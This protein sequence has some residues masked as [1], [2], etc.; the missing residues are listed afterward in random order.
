MNTC[1]YCKK[2]K[3]KRNCPALNGVICSQCC[4]KSRIKFI[5]C[6]DSCPFLKGHYQYTKERKGE[7]FASEWYKNFENLRDEYIFVLNIFQWALYSYLMDSPNSL[8]FEILSGLEYV[9][10]KFSPIT[11]PGE[12]RNKFG[13][14]LLEVLNIGIK[15]GELKRDSISEVLDKLINFIKKYSGGSFRS[16]EFVK[17]FIG[18]M[19][20]YNQDIVEEIKERKESSLIKLE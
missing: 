18:Y 10:R 19:E 16:N 11:I 14:N 1:V 2:R 20:K 4:G 17:G 9:R 13:E 15:E 5:P 6:P 3:G 12:I 7:K 8:D